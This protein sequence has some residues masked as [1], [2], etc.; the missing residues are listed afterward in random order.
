MAATATTSSAV[1][2][3]ISILSLVRSKAPDSVIEES[4]LRNL[5]GLT[6]STAHVSHT[7]YNFCGLGEKPV[8]LIILKAREFFGRQT[9]RFFTGF[10]ISLTYNLSLLEAYILGREEL[11]DEEERLAKLEIARAYAEQRRIYI[12]IVEDSTSVECHLEDHR[13]M[14]S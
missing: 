4:V 12:Y 2:S 11:K 8:M 14:F 3:R 13:G 9:R 10:P 7:R 5:P 1:K 6:Y